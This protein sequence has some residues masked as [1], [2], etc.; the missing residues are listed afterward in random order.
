MG[1]SEAWQVRAGCLDPEQ[2]REVL[3]VHLKPAC[4]VELRHKADVSNGHSGADSE[5]TLTLGDEA[6]AHRKAP[7]HSFRCKPWA[8]DDLL[9]DVSYLDGPLDGQVLQRLR[10]RV[11][12]LGN[13]QGPCSSEGILGM[14]PYRDEWSSLAGKGIV[15][16]VNDGQGLCDRMCH[17]PTVCE[18]ERRHLREGVAVCEVGLRLLTA[19]QQI[20][21]LEAILNSIVGQSYACPPAAGRAPVAVQYD[22]SKPQRSLN[23]FRVRHAGPGWKDLSGAHPKSDFW[24]SVTSTS[25]ADDDSVVVLEELPRATVS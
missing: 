18:R 1:G 8:V 17:P 13:L 21:R 2:M 23:S 20:H 19:L 5:A 3:K 4:I 10:A 7:P 16:E 22:V 14:R 25:T 11:D 24:L 6:L 12:N 15:E 9:P